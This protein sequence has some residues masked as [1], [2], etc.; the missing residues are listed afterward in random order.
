[1]NEKER[2]GNCFPCHVFKIKDAVDAH[3]ALGFQYKASKEY[4]ESILLEDGTLLHKNC[5]FD[6]GGREIIPCNICGGLMLRQ[7]SVFDDGFGGAEEIRIP[8]ASVEEADLLNIFLSEEDFANYPFR[9]FRGNGI[10]SC[11]EGEKEPY[12]YDLDELRTKIRVKDSWLGPSQKV[13]LENLIRQ[14]GK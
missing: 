2:S 4:G 12:P 1:M 14:A 13:L 5:R 11:W 10:S 3:K 9:H 6:E 8:V 7:R